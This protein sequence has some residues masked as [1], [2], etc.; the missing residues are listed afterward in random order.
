MKKSIYDIFRIPYYYALITRHGE[1]VSRAVVPIKK[2]KVKYFRVKGFKAVFLLPDDKKTGIPPLKIKSGRLLVYNAESVTPMK[3]TR[4]V[5][6]TDSNEEL[7]EK[8][9]EENVHA[10]SPEQFYLT[11]VD[12]NELNEFLDAKIVEDIM[13]DATKEIPM[14]VIFLIAGAVV[15]ALILGMGYLVTHGVTPTPQIIYVTPTPTPLPTFG[16]VV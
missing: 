15:V 16:Q 14:W 8:I 5:I 1:V 9:E 2:T 11:P 10:I 3:L 13:S 7:Y 4:R 6:E 12:I